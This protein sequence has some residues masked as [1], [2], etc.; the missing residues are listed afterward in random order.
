MHSAVSNSIQLHQSTSIGGYSEPILEIDFIVEPLQELLET[1]DRP[2]TDILQQLAVLAVRFQRDY[3]WE[4][5]IDWTQKFRTDTEFFRC[6][7]GTS[8]SQLAD[9]ISE[10]DLKAFRN[11][12]PQSIIY[13]DD[14]LKSLAL[15]WNR[16]SQE[17]LECVVA[18]RQLGHK[19]ADLAAVSGLA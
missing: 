4:E 9:S 18:S 17:V 3:Q 5:E 7:R 12:G 11:L 15:R 1:Q 2:V 16:L 19:I 14:Q 8:P 6:I 13:Q 10:C